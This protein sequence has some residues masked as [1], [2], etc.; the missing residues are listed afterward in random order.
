MIY[1]MMNGRL[2]ASVKNCDGKLN[3]NDIDRVSF[4]VKRR[5]D[6]MKLAV[7]VPI[8]EVGSKWAG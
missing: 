6:F 7:Y 2:R 3:D 4:Q 1:K 5:T 8:E